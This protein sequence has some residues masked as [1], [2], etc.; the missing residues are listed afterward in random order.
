[1]ILAPCG[2]KRIPG[3]LTTE[4]L[5][6]CSPR[7]S[8]MWDRLSWLSAGDVSVDKTMPP[9]QRTRKPNLAKFRWPSRHG[10]LRHYGLRSSKE[11]TSWLPMW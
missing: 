10:A 2:A 7:D 6:V 4:S 11:P 8:K 1:M 5:L 3:L 9:K